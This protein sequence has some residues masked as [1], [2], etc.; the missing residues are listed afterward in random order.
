MA[1]HTDDYIKI[2]QEMQTRINKNTRGVYCN[3]YNHLFI[4]VADHIVYDKRNNEIIGKIKSTTGPVFFT[5]IEGWSNI[6]SF[7]MI[8]DDSRIYTFN[9]SGGQFSKI[10]S[11]NRK[12]KTLDFKRQESIVNNAN[13]AFLEVRKNLNEKIDSM[14][15]DFTRSRIEM[16]EKIKM[17]IAS[18]LSDSINKIIKEEV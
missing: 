1:R 16:E 15:D 9:L 17:T 7:F 5:E 6:Q 10:I 2:R 18:E 13:K 3:E 8:V 4:V 11:S 14:I 12:N